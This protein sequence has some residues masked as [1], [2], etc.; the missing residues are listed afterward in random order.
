MY[1]EALLEQEVVYQQFNNVPPETPPTQPVVDPGGAITALS[2]NTLTIGLKSGGAQPS[3]A[4]QALGPSSSPT[5]STV[6]CTILNTSDD[7][8]SR[9]NLGLG[10]LATQ[11]RGVAVANLAG[12]ER[13][14]AL[15]CDQLHRVPFGI[16]LGI[17]FNS[18]A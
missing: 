14:S 5:F 3:D 12:A 7:A 16:R 9:A 8:T 1:R 10:N 18:Q 13:G 17:R 2:S 6:N 4:P 15:A 11:N